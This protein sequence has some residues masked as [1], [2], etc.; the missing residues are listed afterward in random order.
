[1]LGLIVRLL[2]I[3]L[4]LRLAIQFVGG[5]MRGLQGPARPAPKSTAR[6]D[7]LA[8]DLV[9]D[10]ICNTF[11]PRSSAIAGRLEGRDVY[12]CSGACRD[13]AVARDRARIS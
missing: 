8:T 11:V 2:A 13:T 10:P 4:I 6:R 7:S 12:F 1:M 9:R 5:L 3:L